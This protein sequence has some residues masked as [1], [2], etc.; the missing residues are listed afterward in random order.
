MEPLCWCSNDNSSDSPMLLSVNHFCW[1]PNAHHMNIITSVNSHDKYLDQQVGHQLVSLTSCFD[2]SHWLIFNKVSHWCWLFTAVQLSPCS[3][4]IGCTESREIIKLTSETQPVYIYNDGGCAS[5]NCRRIVI[6]LSIK[7]NDYSW[8]EALTTAEWTSMMGIFIPLTIFKTC[9]V[10]WMM[11]IVN[12]NTLLRGRTQLEL[13][14]RVIKQ[15]GT[16]PKPHVILFN[17][18]LK[19]SCCRY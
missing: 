12:D 16:I 11:Q 9:F 19:G 6:P 15:V 2:F 18:K 8:G 3:I 7:F 10:T 13:L 4:M 14:I 17:H 5:L 1:S